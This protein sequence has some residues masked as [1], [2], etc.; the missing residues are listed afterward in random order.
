[1]YFEFRK[2][3]KK[4]ETL[5]N[6]RPTK[7]Q[8]RTL[9]RPPWFPT[10][11]LPCPLLFP[12]LPL[13]FLSPPLALSHACTG[14]QE[15][16]KATTP[17]PAPLHPTGALPTRRILR[18][19]PTPRHRPTPRAKPTSPTSATPTRR[20]LHRVQPRNARASQRS[21]PNVYP[22]CPTP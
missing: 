19:I 12:L 13:P 6:P 2:R 7:A 22:A 14:S 9:V 3:N 10:S 5:P 18:L 15:A 4:R 21:R 8:L 20:G 11:Q 16:T 1:M 17:P